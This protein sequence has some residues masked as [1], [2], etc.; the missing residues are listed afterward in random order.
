MTKG[1]DMA[2]Y[3]YQDHIGYKACCSCPRPAFVRQRGILGSAR[4]P[5]VMATIDP[6]PATNGRKEAAGE[7]EMRDQVHTVC[8][9]DH[10]PLGRYIDIMPQ[11]RSPQYRP[12]SHT[13]TDHYTFRRLGQPDIALAPARL[14]QPRVS[15]DEPLHRASLSLGVCRI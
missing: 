7:A 6:G 4:Q 2:I 1:Y 14:R 3:I 5:G 12:H 8:I 11:P 15:A 10:P 9:V 13:R